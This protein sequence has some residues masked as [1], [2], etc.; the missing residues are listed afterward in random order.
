MDKFLSKNIGIFSD[1]HIG[2]CQDSSIWHEIILD[3]G[4]WAS[5]TFEARGINEIVIPGDI[6]HNRSEISVKTMDI[7]KQFFDMFKDFRLVISTG[8]HDCYKKLDS[9]IHSLSLLKEWKNIEVVDSVPRIFK[10]NFDKTVSVIPWG[11][12]LEDMPLADIMFSHLDIISFYQNGYHLCEKGFSTS[13]LFKK[14]KVIISGHF[15]KR[16]LRKY[17]DGYILYNGSPMQHNFGDVGDDRGI[18]ILN[19]ENNEIEFIHNII[20]PIHKKIRISDLITKKIGIK[21]LK[22]SIP[23]NIINLIIDSQLTPDIQSVLLSKINNLGPKILKI[24]HELHS[25]VSV[26]EEIETESTDIQTII[27]EYINLMDYQEKENLK[28]YLDELYSRFNT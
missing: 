18:H 25:I 3:F 26:S 19:L 28:S 2:I 17:K 9:E 16:D 10:T 4:K 1:I 7:A 22:E 11:T 6:F 8:N 14:S 27:S 15:H 23:N 21:E 24:D 13:D 20:S 5:E 12:L